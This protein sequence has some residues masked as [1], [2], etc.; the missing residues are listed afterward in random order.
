MLHFKLPG[1]HML[2]NEI[3]LD[4]DMF[5]SS[6]SLR[7]LGGCDGCLIVALDRERRS[8]QSSRLCGGGLLSAGPADRCA[9]VEEDES[10][11]RP[12]SVEA[13]TIVCIAIGNESSWIFSSITEFQIFRAFQIGKDP[14][15]SVPVRACVEC[16]KFRDL[17]ESKGNVWTG[18]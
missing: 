6:V 13:T 9:V 14:F 7:T 4:G 16:T 1:P 11:C 10:G 17:P 12:S 3:H 8:V 5:H 18:C 2:A 15:D